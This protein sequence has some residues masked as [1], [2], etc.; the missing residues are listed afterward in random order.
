[1]RKTVLRKE[2]G[3]FGPKALPRALPGRQGEGFPPLL[4][5]K[6]FDKLLR[7][8]QDGENKIVAGSHLELSK[9]RP[10][11]IVRKSIKEEVAKRDILLFE[12]GNAFMA[13]LTVGKS[14]Q[15][16]FVTTTTRS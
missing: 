8:D 1:M 2:K 9:G 5:V 15:S 6:P 11:L 3:D 7:R 12:K 10:A 16:Q 14:R 4:S 13:V